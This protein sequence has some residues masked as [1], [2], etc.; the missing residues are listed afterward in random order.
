MLGDHDEELD[1]AL[2]AR[3]QYPDSLGVMFVEI[4]ARAALGDINGLEKLIDAG[5]GLGTRSEWTPGGL[6]RRTG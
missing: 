2:L 3:A 1:D 6:L 5:I 4:R